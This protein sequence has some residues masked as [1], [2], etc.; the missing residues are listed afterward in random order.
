MKAAV[1]GGDLAR[2][3]VIIQ[4]FNKTISDRFVE[5]QYNIHASHLQWLLIPTIKPD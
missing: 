2:L 4:I 3:Y 5:E 1:L